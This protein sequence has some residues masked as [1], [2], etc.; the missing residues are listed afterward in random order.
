[1]HHNLFLVSTNLQNS[2]HSC[3]TWRPPSAIQAWTQI[4]HMAISYRW[5]GCTQDCRCLWSTCLDSGHPLVCFKLVLRFNGHQNRPAKPVNASK[6]VGPNVV[7]NYQS[8]LDLRLSTGLPESV[9][10]HRLHFQGFMKMAIKVAYGLEKRSADKHWVSASS[11]LL[12]DVHRT[13]PVDKEYNGSRKFYAKGYTEL[14]QGLCGWSERTSEME[15]AAASGNSRKLF[16]LIRA[17][18]CRKP[19]VSEMVYEVGGM[20]I[21]NLQRCLER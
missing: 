18:D 9:D 19:G 5:C 3:T 6:L 21:N 1:M 8:E 2:H 14:E 10:E 16:Q 11:L 12:L 4:D 15:A 7:A 20:P 17:T 13:I